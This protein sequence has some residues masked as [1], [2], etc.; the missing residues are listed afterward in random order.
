MKTDLSC[1]GMTKNHGHHILELL[2]PEIRME[3]TADNAL[4]A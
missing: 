2:V 4:D 3:K 1:K